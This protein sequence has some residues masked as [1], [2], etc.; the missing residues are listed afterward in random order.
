MLKRSTLL[1]AACAAVSGCGSAP[2]ATPAVVESEAAR[3]AAASAIEAG[4]SSRDAVAKSEQVGAPE[5]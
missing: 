3:Q 4:A 5:R 1:L 2:K